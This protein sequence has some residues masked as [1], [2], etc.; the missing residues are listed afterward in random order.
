MGEFDSVQDV[1]ELQR[2][3]NNAFAY[4]LVP[5]S[6]P[7]SPVAAAASTPRRALRS[8]LPDSRRSLTA[9]RMFLSSSATSTTPLPTIS[10]PRL[11]SSPPLSRPPGGST[12]SPPPSASSRASSPRLRRRA[13]IP[14]R[15]NN[16]GRSVGNPKTP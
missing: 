15:R 4:D 7:P 2:N 3:L 9:S 8:F 6:A 16:F 13:S 10:S 11:P 1:F 5:A 12:T 14:R